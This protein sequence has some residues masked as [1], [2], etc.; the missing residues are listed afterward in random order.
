MGGL[1][2]IINQITEQA[3]KK[4]DEIKAEAK[5]KSDRLFSDA[6]EAMQAVADEA[7]ANLSKE[8][9]ARRHMAES[10]QLREKKQMLLK[11]RTQML[12]EI[13]LEAKNKL[14][15]LPDA[16]YVAWMLRLFQ[17]YAQNQD[18]Q[19]LVSDSEKKRLGADFITQCNALLKSG[20]VSYA[21]ESISAPNGFIIRY[22]KIEENCTLDGIFADRLQELRDL[23]AS[24]LDS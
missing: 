21:E 15:Q 11:I 8:L 13:I 16:E 7:H 4:A 6:Q 17:H 19:I 12:D 9:T 23:A 14:S 18:G 2:A 22:G 3:T 20:S 1:E 10:E 5:K 24:C